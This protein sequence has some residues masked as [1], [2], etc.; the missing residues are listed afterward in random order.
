MKD[1]IETGVR[2]Y[3]GDNYVFPEDITHVN[4]FNK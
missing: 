3:P 1:G 2:V 4:W